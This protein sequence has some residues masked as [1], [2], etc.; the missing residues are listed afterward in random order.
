MDRSK[1]IYLKI[2]KIVS[3]EGMFRSNFF[4]L[5][6]KIDLLLYGDLINKNTGKS[7]GVFIPM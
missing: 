7:E 3:S 1:K 5:K 2:E 6:G 4:G